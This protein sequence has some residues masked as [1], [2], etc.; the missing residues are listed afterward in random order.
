LMVGRDLG[1]LYSRSS[2]TPANV[3]LSVNDLRTTKVRSATFQLHRGEV[4]GIFGLVG[5]GRTELLNALFG[6]EPVQSGTVV[7]QSSLRQATPS[8]RWQQSVGLVGEDRRSGLAL[9]MSVAENVAL[10]DQSLG[11]LLGWLSPS[12]LG[13]IASEWIRKLGIK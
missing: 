8:L 11:G 6:L 12:H 1:D 9:G 2:R 3:V 10:P 4:L 5:A 13:R 7:V